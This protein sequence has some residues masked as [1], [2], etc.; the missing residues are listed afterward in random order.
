MTLLKK[1]EKKCNLLLTVTQRWVYGIHIEGNHAEENGTNTMNK[2]TNITVQLP[3]EISYWGSTATE[4]HVDRIL[5][6]LE[7]MIAKE[8]SDSPYNINFER[9]ANPSGSGIHGDCE[10]ACDD[11]RLFIEENWMNAL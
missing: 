8:F 11:V 6:N 10:A 3:T 9:T 7:T 4:A 2:D 5:S 1:V